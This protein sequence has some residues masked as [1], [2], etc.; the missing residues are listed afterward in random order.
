LI[1]VVVNLLLLLAGI[2]SKFV[3]D[4]ELV[5]IALS[6]ITFSEIYLVWKYPELLKDKANHVPIENE[7]LLKEKIHLLMIGEKPYKNPELNLE[8]LARILDMKP[9]TLSRI[10]NEYFCKNFRD[11]VNGYRIEEFIKLAENGMLE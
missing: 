6:L 1:G 9:Y 8:L 3:I 11:F 5:F 10:L 2:S 4:H 7:K